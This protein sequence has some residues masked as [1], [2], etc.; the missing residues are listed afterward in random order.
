MDTIRNERDALRVM[1]AMEGCAVVL[2]DCDRQPDAP[3]VEFAR[4][5][6]TESM[7]AMERELVKWRQSA[8]TA[9]R[10]PAG[11][12]RQNPRPRQDAEAESF[13]RRS[14]IAA[15]ASGQA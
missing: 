5:I 13:G 1:R 4:R 9:S 14:L 10:A 8:I 12:R 15:P 2:R 11:R 3:G 7:T 6:V